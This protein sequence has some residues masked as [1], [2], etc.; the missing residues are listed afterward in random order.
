MFT[1]WC[2]RVC[3][4]RLAFGGHLPRQPAFGQNS[5]SSPFVTEGSRAAR[6]WSGDW[7][8]RDSEPGSPRGPLWP[9]W[10]FSEASSSLEAPGVGGSYRDSHLPL[11]RSPQRSLHAK[12]WYPSEVQ[13]GWASRAMESGCPG[14]T[15]W[16]LCGG[17]VLRKRSGTV[18]ALALWPLALA[19]S[20]ALAPKAPASDDVGDCLGTSQ[21][22]GPPVPAGWPLS[23]ALSPQNQS[24]QGGGVFGC[25][26][27]L[28]DPSWDDCSDPNASPTLRGQ[29]RSS[30]QGLCRGSVL[31]KASEGPGPHRTSQCSRSWDLPW[32]SGPGVGRLITT[33]EG[34]P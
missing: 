2:E 5:V 26:M 31:R 30:V 25:R 11:P 29:I 23:Q 24:G 17:R 16:P 1:P 4:W 12:W 7:S 3:H 22:I 28:S 19:L 13:E 21:P 18:S 9:P 32:A 15:P 6:P 20:V 8:P 34:H 33:R 10:P 14:G 27:L